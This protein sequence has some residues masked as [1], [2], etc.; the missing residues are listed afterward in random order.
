MMEPASLLLVSDVLRRRRS[1]PDFP[2]GPNNAIDG[3]QGGTRM[4]DTRTPY[5]DGRQP[6]GAFKENRMNKARTCPMCTTTV[7]WCGNCS[8]NHHSGG[9]QTCPGKQK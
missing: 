2:G 7:Q 5:A 6:C 9:W 4:P 3:F 8:Q 1:A